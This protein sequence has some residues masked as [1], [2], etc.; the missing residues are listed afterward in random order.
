MNQANKLLQ[1]DLQALEA[2]N[3]N[4]VALYQ[5]QRAEIERLRAIVGGYQPLQ[6][7]L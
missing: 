2:E 7:S 6:R 1:E 4:W 5:R 3:R